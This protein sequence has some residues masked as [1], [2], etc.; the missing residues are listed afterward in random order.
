TATA[1]R[2][3][4]AVGLVDVV[5]TIL[6]SLGMPV[7]QELSGQSFLPALLGPRH[8][9]GRAAVSGVLDTYRTAAGGRYTLIQHGATRASLYD[10]TTDPGET[11]D[12]SETHPNTLRWLRSVLG[13]RLAETTPTGTTASG[14]RRPRIQAERTR[15]DPETEAQLRALGY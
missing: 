15:I 13:L 8:R 3:P 2:V 4:D 12:V 7:P 9:E 10:L 1:P 6:E 11:R 14:R 5:P